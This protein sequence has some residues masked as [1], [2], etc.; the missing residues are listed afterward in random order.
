MKLILNQIQNIPEGYSEVMYNHK[1]YGLVKE[2]F[3]DQKSFKIYAEELGGKDFIS[4]NFYKMSHK[5]VLKPCEMPKDKVIHFL[6]N[7]QT[8]STCF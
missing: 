3:N 4:L 2:T 6:N 5:N 1:K 8:I 7:H